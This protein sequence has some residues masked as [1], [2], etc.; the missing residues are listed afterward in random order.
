MWKVNPFWR[1]LL[2]RCQR[3]FDPF[4]W[5]KRTIRVTTVA[6]FLIFL[7]L[8][9]FVG[10]EAASSV[11]YARFPTLA[12]PEID[13]E[14]PVVTLELQDRQLIAPATVAGSYSQN[15]NKTLIIG[16]ASTVFQHLN[17][18]NQ[19][20]RLRYDNREY[21]IQTIETFE[22]TDVNMR[23]V[24]APANTD[25]IIIMTCAGQPLPNQDATHRLIVTATLITDAQPT[26]T[27]PM[28]GS[29]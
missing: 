16:H 1:D 13:L 17:Q 9:I 7:P 25:T 5:S 21:Q 20:D 4:C 11:D 10:M 14:T 29:R 18:L 19:T 15:P 27:Q 12:I 2:R 23:Q 24:L 8:Y 6:F 28:L 3:L 22:K 26:A